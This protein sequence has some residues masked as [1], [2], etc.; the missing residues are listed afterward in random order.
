MPLII[1]LL[2]VFACGFAT[3]ILF[4]GKGI[5]DKV[6]YLIYVL[7]F[8]PIIVSLGLMSLHCIRFF[9]FKNEEDF[10][11]KLVNDIVADIKKEIPSLI[12][13]SIN[14]SVTKAMDSNITKIIESV[15]TACP[16][17]QEPILGQFSKIN[18]EK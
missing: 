16:N 7:A 6:F 17:S 15:K 1:A 2:A 14:S 12:E 10:R 18:L 5:E 4:F 9:I 13:N 3:I 8:L 11:K